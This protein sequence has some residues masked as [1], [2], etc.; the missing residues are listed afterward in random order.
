MNRQA[1]VSD[2]P[3]ATGA[4][5]YRAPRVAVRP[6]GAVLM[7][8]AV[9]AT[10][11]VAC[12]SSGAP[13]WTFAPVPPLTTALVSH[14]GQLFACPPASTPDE[15]GPIDQARPTNPELFAFD[16]QAG[17][18]V[19]LVAATYG[20]ETWTF[21]VCT[22]AWTRMDP[23]REPP[24]T[25]WRP[26]VYDVDSGV[27]ILVTSGTVWAYD[28]AANRWA[29][30]GAAP[31]DA[32]P[33]A[34]DPITGLV[35]AASYA[36]PGNLWTYEVETAFWTSI[37]TRY[38]PGGVTFAYAAYDASVDRIVAYDQGGSTWL[39]DIRTGTWS[40]AGAGTPIVVA[41]YGM[42]TPKIV[43]DDAAERTVVFGNDR[44][45]VYH[46]TADRWEVLVAGGN[47]FTPDSMVYDAVNG[48]LVG[49][50]DTDGVVAFDLTTREWTI[51]LASSGGQPAPGSE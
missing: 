3:T 19:T 43:Y 27:T 40:L 30:K 21:D 7:S 23:D 16:R 41:G 51:L 12:A 50:A 20:V 35:V 4:R 24:R 37:R 17:R 1:N 38:L 6:I 14:V 44:L 22:N 36:T 47:D 45:A 25:E 8:I 42:S 46:A 39:F 15:P 33:W 26:P 2:P 5:P 29:D 32:T 49:I 48:R 34:Y 28:H 9:L 10:I 13:S 31:N 11:L 18:L